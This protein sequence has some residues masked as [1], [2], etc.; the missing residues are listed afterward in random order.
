MGVKCTAC[1]DTGHVCEEHPESPWEGLTGPVE[2]HPACGGAGI[3][4]PACCSPVTSGGSIA[5]AFTPDWMRR[6][7]GG[8]PCR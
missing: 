7:A 8:A 3:P 6:P 5:V 1:R 2:G 4:C